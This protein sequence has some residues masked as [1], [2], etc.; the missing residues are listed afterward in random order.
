MAKSDWRSISLDRMLLAWALAEP[1]EWG[2]GRPADLVRNVEAREPLTAGEEADAIRWLLAG[3]RG[4]E[5]AAFRALDASWYEADLPI[6]EVGRAVPHAHWRERHW[7]MHTPSTPPPRD[8]AEFAK[9]VDIPDS[10]LGE[11]TPD[12]A[13]SHRP[14]L[15]CTDERGPWRV[16][17]GNHRVV[18]VWQAHLRG[19]PRYQAT[20]RVLLGIHPLMF[21][22]GDYVS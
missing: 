11:R 9:R 17:E 1:N 14:I 22:W 20:C 21:T 18:A 19:D 15:L 3:R 6:A 5:T 12:P 8:V 4:H 10:F 16:A 7:V 2:M 13:K